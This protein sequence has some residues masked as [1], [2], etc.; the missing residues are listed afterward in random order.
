MARILV[1]DDD[2]DV[3]KLIRILL[4]SK[5]H[6]VTEAEDGEEGI[7]RITD[8]IDLVVTD[9]NMPKIDGL[10]LLL[11]IKRERPT[12]PIIAVSGEG[13][14]GGGINTWS[15]DKLGA[16]QIFRKPFDHE[17]FLKTVAKF[18]GKE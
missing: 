13:A 17:E 16:D 3:R 8:D 15:A 5:D 1:I 11:Q 4:E 12:L 18:T 7:R 9:I 14:L 6:T 10:E 2:P